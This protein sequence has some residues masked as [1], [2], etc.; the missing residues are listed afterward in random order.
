M[1][2]RLFRKFDRLAYLHGVPVAPPPPSALVPSQPRERAHVCGRACV[3][4]RGRAREGF[5]KRVAVHLRARR[6]P[7]RLRRALPRATALI[8]LTAAAATQKVDVI[9]DA[10]IAATNFTED[11]VARPPSRGPDAPLPALP[12]S[13][14]SAPRAH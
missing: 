5:A 11:Q 13:D 2:D 9:G 6:A 10:Y 7:C 12:P 4:V 8:A 3:D 14:M 1:L